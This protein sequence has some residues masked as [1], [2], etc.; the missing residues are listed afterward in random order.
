MKP[1]HTYQDRTSRYG[2]G[3]THDKR[4]TVYRFAVPRGHSHLLVGVQSAAT[5]A[6]ISSV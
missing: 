3:E 1:D 2:K 6:V 5:S 4:R